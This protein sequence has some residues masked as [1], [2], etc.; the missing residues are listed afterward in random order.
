MLFFL[1]KDIAI[2]TNKKESDPQVVTIT[3]NIKRQKQL[4]ALRLM[5]VQGNVLF[6]LGLQ[7]S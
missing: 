6:L 7:S 5:S 1:L 2:K 4:P 3:A